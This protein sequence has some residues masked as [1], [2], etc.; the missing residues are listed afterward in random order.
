MMRGGRK[1]KEVVKPENIEMYDS[2]GWLE[3][4]MYLKQ[5]GESLLKNQHDSK[6]IRRSDESSNDRTPNQLLE[7]AQRYQPTE[8]TEWDKRLEKCEKNLLMTQQDS[9]GRKRKATQH[10][11]GKGSRLRSKEI[12]L[13]TFTFSGSAAVAGN[14]LLKVCVSEKSIQQ[15][16]RSYTLP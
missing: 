15:T 2:N 7:N 10:W 16:K 11:I 6:D 14:K 9:K 3:R 5:L 13:V 8:W 1:V 12:I 4:A